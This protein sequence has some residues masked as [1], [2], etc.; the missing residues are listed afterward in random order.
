MNR[1]RVL[2]GSESFYPS[3]SGVSVTTFNLAAYLSGKG[4]EVAVVAPSPARNTYHERFPEGFTVWRIG[5]ISNPFR[6]EFRVTINPRRQVREIV[7]S[8]QPTLI[9]LQDPTSIAYAL[10]IEA[11]RRRI[12]VVISHHFSLD[13][14]LAYLRFLKP[15]H[16]F[17]RR[18]ITAAMLKFYNSC[19]SVIC[20]S[21]TA[22]A[23]LLA[24]GL[25]T[26]T[27]AVSNGVDLNRFF[28]YQPLL[29]P[30]VFRLPN[31]PLVLYVGR[32]D[33]DKNLDVLLDAV[34][35]V[36]ARCQAHF[37]LCGGGAWKEKLEKKVRHKGLADFVSFL[38]PYDHRSPELPWLYQLAHCFVLPSGI[39]T[40]SIATLE[41][42]ASGLPVVAAHGGALPELVTDEENGFLF[43]P[44]YAEGLAEGVIRILTDTELGKTMGRHSLE[45]AFLHRMEGSLQKIDSVY[46][47]VLENAQY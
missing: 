31:Q 6:R 23:E 27:T 33:Q 17:L 41:A 35:F 22:R 11:Q 40:Q 38:G 20:P 47:Q 32:L 46:D 7:E 45:K 44:G 16:P 10:R 39:E 5:S 1:K 18:R 3:I 42:M 43:R 13:Y 9:H 37:V 30:G 19:Q 36:L 24:A 4:H 21:E 2:V 15:I 29:N 28:A 34:P 8:W 25:K 14:I 26:P 12:P